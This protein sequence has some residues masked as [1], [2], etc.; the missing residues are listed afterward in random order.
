MPGWTHH[1]GPAAPDTVGTIVLQE[2]DDAEV[3][4]VGTDVGLVQGAVIVLVDL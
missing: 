3:V 1:T 2:L 4:V